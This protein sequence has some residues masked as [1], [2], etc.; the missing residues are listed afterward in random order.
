MEL[1][2]Q[3]QFKFRKLTTI[4]FIAIIEGLFVDT[5]TPSGFLAQFS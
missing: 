1:Y 4:A 5:E 2:L 3:L